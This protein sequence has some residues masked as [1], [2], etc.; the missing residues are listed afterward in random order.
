MDRFKS[1]GRYNTGSRKFTKFAGLTRLNEVL[2]F[3]WLSKWEDKIV[4]EL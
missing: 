3:I 1:M 4:V 2:N